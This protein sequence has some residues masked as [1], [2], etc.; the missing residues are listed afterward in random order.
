MKAFVLEVINHFNNRA[1]QRE[2][3]AQRIYDVYKNEPKKEDEVSESL[4]ET[5]G[6]N[7]NLIPDDTFVLVGFYK[8]ESLNWI[9]KNGLYNARADSSRGSLRLGPGETGAKYLL[10]HST[11]ETKTG[12]LLKIVETGPRVFSKQTLI[13]KGYP[14]VPS[15]NY[16]LVYKIQEITDKEFMYQEW[17]ITMLEKYRQGHASALPFSVTLTELMK[18][19]I[20]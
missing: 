6:V 8:R 19:V 13:D 2:K 17:D 16:Y 10:L 14:T 4:P 15:Q 18:T 5:F 11:D 9:I 12:R 1:S 7:R 3:I 20:K